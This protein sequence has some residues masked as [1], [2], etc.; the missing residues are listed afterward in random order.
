PLCAAKPS[1]GPSSDAGLPGL[2]AVRAGTTLTFSNAEGPLV[3][4][5]LGP[6][7]E[8][9]GSNR[10]A[11]ARYRAFF[12]AEDV[13]AVLVTG[14]AGEVAEGITQVLADLAQLGKPVLTIIGNRECASVYDEGV[15]AAQE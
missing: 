9:S 12:E 8:A 7:N 1:A 11:L 13:D 15:R 5:V 3:L 14:D 4:G 2:E 6:I 10:I